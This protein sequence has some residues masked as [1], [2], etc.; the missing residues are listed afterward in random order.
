METKAATLEVPIFEHNAHP[1]PDPGRALASF[2]VGHLTTAGPIKFLC[3]Q[4][5]FLPKH[6]SELA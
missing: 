4:S 5:F 3:L 1:F 6:V 2:K